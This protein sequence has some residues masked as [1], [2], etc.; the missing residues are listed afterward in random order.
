MSNTERLKA[1][2]VGVGSMGTHHAR[3]YNEL[4]SVDLVG[5]ADANAS[6]AAATAETMATMPP[7]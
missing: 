7:T 1:G 2:V 4:P 6:H 3:V 5:V